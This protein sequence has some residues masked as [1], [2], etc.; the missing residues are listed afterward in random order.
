MSKMEIE[1]EMPEASKKLSEQFTLKDESFGNFS[2][3]LPAFAKAGPELLESGK[4]LRNWIV[5]EHA[6]PQTAT[7][8]RRNQLRAKRAQLST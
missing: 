1:E 7:S 4:Y 2:L 6:A 8:A 3:A 5:P